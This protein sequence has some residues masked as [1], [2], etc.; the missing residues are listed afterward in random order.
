MRTCNCTCNYYCH[1][2]ECCDG[3]QFIEF[4]YCSAYKFK[5]FTLISEGVTKFGT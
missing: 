5:E 2:S 1:L 3:A 4:S